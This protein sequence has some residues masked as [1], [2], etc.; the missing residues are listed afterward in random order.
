MQNLL[1]GEKVQEIEEIGFIRCK[2]D[3][4]K[5][6]ATMQL[7]YRSP[8]IKREGIKAIKYRYNLSEMEKTIKKKMH[9]N[10]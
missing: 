7:F 3:K 5:L 8:S 9:R 1:F 4:I 2:K 10:T 6:R